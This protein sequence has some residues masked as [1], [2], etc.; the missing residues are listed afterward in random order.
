[1][2]I[3]R[4]TACAA[5]AASVTAA[6]HAGPLAAQKDGIAPL[7]PAAFVHAQYGYERYEGGD[8]GPGGP[9]WRGGWPGG[10]YGRP[11][12]YGDPP[13]QPRHWPSQWGGGWYGG[14]YQPYWGRDAW[15]S[16]NWVYG[17]EHY[18]GHYPAPSACGPNGCGEPAP[19][20]VPMK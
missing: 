14:W 4:L 20:Y 7:G 9:G 6:A 15:A 18:Y 10:W 11:G 16:P 13:G 5:I 3:L 8:G 19:D 17:A 1:M 2:K 12:W